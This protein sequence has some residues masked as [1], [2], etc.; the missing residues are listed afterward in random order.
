MHFDLSM[1][2]AG[3][4]AENSSVDEIRWNFETMY[5][6]A[7][8]IFIEGAEEGDTLEITILSLSPG[9]W[10]WTMII[11]GR[12]LLPDD[13]CDPYLRIFDLRD[14]RKTQLT[15]G[16]ELPIRPFLGTM[17]VA[18]N[19]P[20]KLAVFPPHKGGGNI[21]TRHLIAGSTLWL[22]VWV[23]GGLFSCGDPHA[24]QGDGEVCVSA[25]ECRMKASLKFGLQKTRC[26]GP[27]YRTPHVLDGAG[28]CYGTMGIHEDLMEG[29]R[30]AVRNMITWL[31]DEH[32]LRRED[33]YILCSL[34]GDLRIHEVVDGGV[35]NV[36]F[37]LPLGVF[38]EHSAA[39]ADGCYATQR[40]RKC[41]D[42]KAQSPSS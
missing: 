17:G 21:D 19:E 33:A 41:D 13:F 15:S 34:A 27:S 9:P 32:G 8:P 20:E 14:G 2:G 1:T 4:I 29:A 24:A 38:A 23:E 18:P 7:G 16:I 40:E 5:N 6:L 36:G 25:I 42:R 37:M 3:Q 30:I 12:G 11:P 10:G 22:P 39:S 31:G 26:P 28:P 35:W